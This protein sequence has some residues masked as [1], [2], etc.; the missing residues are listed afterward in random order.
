[1]LL[2]GTMRLHFKLLFMMILCIA[3]VTAHARGQFFRS[4]WYPMYHGER[5]AYCTRDEKKCG[6]DIARAYCQEIG[7]AEAKDQRIEHNV[8][9]TYF[10]EQGGECLG[11]KCDGFLLISCAGKF[12]SHPPKEYTYRIKVFMYPRFEN[13][14]VDWCLNQGKSCG[15]P[16]AYSYC[17]RMGYS[18]DK[19][20]TQDEHVPATKTL[21]DR[22]LCY[23][24][25]CRG[26]EKIECQ[27]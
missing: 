9:K 23:G 17:R 14:R 4:F 11:W 19:Q 16:A 5:L 2:R 13:H 7:Y 3:H 18:K 10:W 26:F 24:K 22:S 25:K 12:K 21:G 1:M 6:Q 15:H 8:G 27:R 20:Y